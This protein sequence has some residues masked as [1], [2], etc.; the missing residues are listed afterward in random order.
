[1]VFTGVP[2]S[3]SSYHVFDVA[4]AGCLDYSF[5][6][7]C[8]E[9]IGFGASGNKLAAVVLLILRFQ[10][11][12][13]LI[14]RH[15]VLSISVPG[16]PD[17]DFP[18]SCSQQLV[19]VAPKQEFAANVF[20]TVRFRTPSELISRFRASSVAFAGTPGTRE[21]EIHFWFRPKPDCYKTR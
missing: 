14:D 6:P 15:R 5:P 7:S 11:S 21:R 20:L 2:R 3:I 13:K 19:F 18:L 16:L 4:V 10:G 1:M 17:T 8:S 12:P 9:H